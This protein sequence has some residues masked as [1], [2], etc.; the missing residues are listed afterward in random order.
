ML[1]NCSLKARA[2]LL[3]RSSSGSGFRPPP[4]VVERKASD[5]VSGGRPSQLP[6]RMPDRIVSVATPAQI[7]FPHG[8]APGYTAPICFQEAWLGAAGAGLPDGSLPP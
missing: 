1:P 4:D 7:P 5:V 6:R 3:S 8:H 2:M